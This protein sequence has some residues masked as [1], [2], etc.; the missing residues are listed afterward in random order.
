M[1][2]LMLHR[3]LE[4]VQSSLQYL[5]ERLWPT[6][7]AALSS[8]TLQ[9]ATDRVP[10]PDRFQ[11]RVQFPRFQVAQEAGTVGLIFAPNQRR[12]PVQE[13]AGEERRRVPLPALHGADHAVTLDAGHSDL[14]AAH[15]LG[16]LGQ[17]ASCENVAVRKCEAVDSSWVGDDSRCVAT[18]LFI[19]HEF[20]C[21]RCRP[22]R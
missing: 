19:F 15:A 2:N 16:S 13:S 4:P 11:V 22:L 14:F 7:L 5:P 21:Q 12:V 20:A 1:S 10:K 17:L 8:F 6:G 9:R 18:Y 3:C